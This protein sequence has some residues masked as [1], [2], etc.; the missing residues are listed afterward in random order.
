MSSERQLGE[1][2]QQK[3]WFKPAHRG[4]RMPGLREES[5]RTV[6]PCRVMKDGSEIKLGLSPG[7]RYREP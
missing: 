7:V 4:W 2:S 1:H 5:W 6:L 3:G